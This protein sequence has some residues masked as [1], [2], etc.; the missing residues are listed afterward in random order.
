[1]PLDLSW[2]VHQRAS[3][4]KTSRTSMHR[5]VP[6]LPFDVTADAW[7]L[8]PGNRLARQEGLESLPQILA[9]HGQTVAGAAVIKLAAVDQF[10]VLVIQK[11]IRRAGGPVG[12]GDF[13][14]GIV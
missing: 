9:G 11:E 7:L 1:M 3:T 5:L 14:R 6:G 2:H 4:K 10:A 13:L 8:V 12:L